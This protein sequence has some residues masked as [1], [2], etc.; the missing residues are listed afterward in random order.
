[1]PAPWSHFHRLRDQ[2]YICVS[3]Y[4]VHSAAAFGNGSS[5]NVFG[6]EDNLFSAA[7]KEPPSEPPK[8]TDLLGLVGLVSSGSKLPLESPTEHSIALS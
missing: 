6:D 7:S 3:L 2:L 1:M 8:V 5:S 4:C